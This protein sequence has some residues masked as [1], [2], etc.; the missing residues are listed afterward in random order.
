MAPRKEV[1]YYYIYSFFGLTHAHST[2]RISLEKLREDYVGCKVFW[3][4]VGKRKLTLEARK[5]TSKMISEDDIHLVHALSTLRLASQ[6]EDE[7][8]RREL[9]RCALHAIDKKCSISKPL[10]I[11]FH[12]FHQELKN[13]LGIKEDER[14]LER[15]PFYTSPRDLVEIFDKNVTEDTVQKLFENQYKIRWPTK[16]GDPEPFNYYEFC[17][18]MKTRCDK[19]VMNYT[20]R[21][22][23][24]NSMLYQAQEQLNEIRHLPYKQL[25]P[26][27]Y[28]KYTDGTWEKCTYE[29]DSLRVSEIGE[30][31]LDWITNEQLKTYIKDQS[32]QHTNGN[33][34]LDKSEQLYLAVLEE[35]YLPD[36]DENRSDKTQVYVGKAKNGIKERWMGSQCSSH[37]RTMERSRNVMC[38]MMNYDPDV[39]ASTMLVDLRFLLHK[40][41]NREGNKSGLFIIKF[42]G[43]LKDAENKLIKGIKLTDT[44]TL[45]PTNME[46]GMKA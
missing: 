45:R 42:S 13:T 6:S 18:A 30:E 5:L 1:V 21:R 20:T 31:N 43:P 29:E 23:H 34:F 12:T 40:V 9:K 14:F 44:F 16:T 28:V 26:P 8:R 32:K 41:N 24:V 10:D 4:I 39:L 46:Y 2:V 7:K 25:C 17:K 36:N 33:S 38:R 37:C 15:K 35:D 19:D 3:N 22:A 27:V 11:N